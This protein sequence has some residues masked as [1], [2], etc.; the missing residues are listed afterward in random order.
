[1]TPIFEGQPPHNKAFSNQ[2]KGHLGSRYAYIYMG[3]SKIEEPQNGWF[4]MENPIKMD[5]LGVPLF[6][7]TTLYSK[8]PRSWSLLTWIART[9]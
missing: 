3:V 6:S 2:H 1:M 7:E 8:Q 9:K 4:I 5:D